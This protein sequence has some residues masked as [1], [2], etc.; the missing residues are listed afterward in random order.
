M[1]STQLE[2]KANRPSDRSVKGPKPGADFLHARSV[3]RELLRELGASYERGQPV[4]PEDLLARWP[5]N[6]AD[7]RDV[8]SLL[9]EDYCRREN[10]GEQPSLAEY[11]QRFPEQ[12]DSLISHFRQHGVLRS[13]RISG[14]EP[15]PLSLPAV[16]DDV[17][18]FRLRHEL[19]AGAFASV[20]LA[21]QVELAG[22]PVVLKVSAADGKEPQTLAQL[23][24]THIVPIYSYHEDLAAGLRAVCMPFFGGASLSRVLGNIWVE[25]SQPTQGAQFVK[26]L[27]AVRAPSLQDVARRIAADRAAPAAA[28][29]V[30]SA[31]PAPAP[32]LERLERGSYIE[33]AAWVVA[34]LADGLHHAHERGILHRD[35][36]PSNILLGADGVPLLLDFNL[37]EDLKDTRNRDVANFGGTVAYMAPEHLRAMASRD[38]ALARKVDHRSDIYSLG[39]VLYEMLVGHKPFDQSASYAPMPA[40]IEAMAVERADVVPSAR[41]R[42]SDVPW[43]LESIVR[44]CL[45]PDPTQRYQRA[46][47]LADDLRALLEHRSLPHA[48]ELSR[49]EQLGKWARRHPRLTATAQ[50]AAVAAVLLGGLATG[51]AAALS[52]WEKTQGQLQAAEEREHLQQ[53]DENTV[54]AFCL[55]STT[56]D[57]QGYDHHPQGLEVCRKSLALYQVLERDD[58]QAQPGWQCLDVGQRRRLLENVREVLLLYAWA[59]A[60][61]QG[62]APESL[63]EA[64]S[65][66]EKAGRIEGLA[67]TTALWHDRA[68]YLE[69][70]G[71]AKE[72]A[73][74]RAQAEATPPTTARD[75]Y[76]LATTTIRTEGATSPAALSELEQAL[77]LNPHHFWALMQRGAC[78]LERGDTLLAVSDFS[79][80]I[81]LRPQAPW[82]YFNRGCAFARAGQRS[83]AV[84]DYTA[85]LERDDRLVLAYLN[86]ALTL[87]EMKRHT[88]ALADFDRAAALGR[89]DAP[90]HAGRGVALE[91]LGRH[92]EA[93]AAFTRALAGLDGLD[94]RTRLRVRWVHGFAVS[95]RL[96]AAAAASFDAV[97]AVDPRQ[98]QALYGRAMLAAA[99]DRLEE[100][101]GYFQRALEADPSFVEARRYRAI[102]LAR[103]GQLPQASLDINDCLKREP[104]SGPTLYAAACVAALALEHADPLHASDIAAQALVLLERAFRQGYGQDRAADDADLAALHDLPAFQRLLKKKF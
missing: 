53:F 32:A 91:A 40:L 46:D 22:R 30:Q 75:Y 82:A 93:D 18:G 103:R 65:L 51:L 39:M 3:K 69:K 27:R 73:Q 1:S 78:R 70:L 99:A 7:D 98:P 100:A 56:S 9:F 59:R 26:A 42:R 5:T 74:A 49:R 68:F 13:L 63:N 62:F 29:L 28:P 11:Q 77:R 14:S 15:A 6:P 61:A 80:A 58:W 38:P 57:L 50:A 34:C 71:R 89:D 12:R 86:R 104:Q 45:H 25:T 90:L 19:G 85:A 17:F 95:S 2:M 72:A 52:G 31:P 4:R 47:H 41:A 88:E 92:P 24:H 64:L 21:E 55:I 84:A 97:L 48:P 54:R 83:A 20:F 94:V 44:K 96:P 33:A 36:K 79:E 23:Q 16:G 87:L 66:V 81:R 67:P 101:L 60:R 35:I 102:L 8:A 76:L 43:G 37:S 10:G